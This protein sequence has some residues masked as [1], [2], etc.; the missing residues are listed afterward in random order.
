MLFKSRSRSGSACWSP[1][2]RAM[3]PSGIVPVARGQGL[4]QLADWHRRNWRAVP[5]TRRRITRNGR[6]HRGRGFKS[7]SY[8]RSLHHHRIVGCRRGS[9]SPDHDDADTARDRRRHDTVGR[10]LA[11]YPNALPFCENTAPFPCPRHEQTRAILSTATPVVGSRPAAGRDAGAHAGHRHGRHPRVRGPALGH[12]GRCLR[13]PARTLCRP[14]TGCRGPRGG[15]RPAGIP[16]GGRR[17]A[18]GP[19]SHRAR[20]GHALDPD[21]PV[22]GPPRPGG[23]VQRALRRRPR[24]ITKTVC[25]SSPTRFRRCSPTP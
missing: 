13:R 3:R 9:S 22:L 23:R 24:R 4:Q 8:S 18:A 19:V 15:P 2:R 11:R 10:R 21:V 6:R 14:A 12:P 1:S 16:G 7:R 25:W 5:F 20:Q 17:H